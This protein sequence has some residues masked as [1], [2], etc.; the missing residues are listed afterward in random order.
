MCPG[1]TGLMIASLVGYVEMVRF[2]VAKGARVE[3]KLAFGDDTALM[4]A[5]KRGHLEVV[6]VL[7]EAGADIDA[8]TTQSEA[9]RETRSPVAFE[10]LMHGQTA[11]LRFLSYYGADLYLRGP[12]NLG[13]ETVSV[14]RACLMEERFGIE[15]IKQGLDRRFALVTRAL[16]PWIEGVDDVAAVICREFLDPTNAA[17]V[18]A[19]VEEYDM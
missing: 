7:C 14:M 18:E 4:T 2:L 1:A 17:Y 15:A 5:A 19:L 11:V 8:T 9:Y 10:A 6:R 16:Q 3:R 13:G 12:S